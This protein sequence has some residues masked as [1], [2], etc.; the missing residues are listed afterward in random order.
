MADEI[1][2]GDIGTIIR[3]T[4][5]DGTTAVNISTATVK[6]IILEKPDGTNLEK[7]ASFYT[8]GVDGIIQ[9]TTILGDLSTS[10]IWK[11]QGLVTMP[12]GTWR[13]T[14]ESFTVYDNL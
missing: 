10:G 5:K 3:A 2:I 13:T 9:Y 11:L 4:V 7:E 6:T 12:S 8:D 14:I 1:R